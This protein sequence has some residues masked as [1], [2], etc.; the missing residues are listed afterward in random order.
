[1]DATRTEAMTCG[2]CGGDLPPQ[3]IWEANRDKAGECDGSVDDQ[4]CCRAYSHQW[5]AYEFIHTHSGYAVERMSD[6][7]YAEFLDSSE[8][9]AACEN[10][11]DGTDSESEYEWQEVG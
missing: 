6:R 8:A 11:N 10:L 2:C 3:R 5:E 9:A 1:M 7:A 4:G